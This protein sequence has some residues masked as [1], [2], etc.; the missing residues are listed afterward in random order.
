MAEKKQ[1]PIEKQIERLEEIVERL[2]AGEVP[3]EKSIELY[4]EGRKLG[5]EAT[6]RLGALEKRIQLVVEKADGELE[7]REFEEME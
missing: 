3:L 6:K 5:S 2:E 7:T 1:P 4:E